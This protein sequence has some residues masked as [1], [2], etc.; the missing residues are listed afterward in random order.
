MRACMDVPVKKVAVVLDD[1][2]IVVNVYTG[3]DYLDYDRNPEKYSKF[4]TEVACTYEHLN[5]AIAKDED[6][7]GYVICK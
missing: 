7:G 5:V 6:T 1:G 3:K 2:R 4:V